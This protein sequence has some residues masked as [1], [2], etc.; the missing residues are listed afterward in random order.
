[1]R[2][3]ED[4]AGRATPS[5]RGKRNA[6]LSL[7]EKTMGDDLPRP[8]GAGRRINRFIPGPLS[9]ADAYIGLNTIKAYIANMAANAGI[10]SQNQ[11]RVYRQ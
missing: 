6:P 1:M 10:P 7:E 3:A 4:H 5:C 8:I 11:V 9:G 2:E